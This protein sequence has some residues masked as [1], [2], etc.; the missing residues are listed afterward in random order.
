M[1]PLSERQTAEIDLRIRESSGVR[2]GVDVTP[3]GMLSIAV[4][5][6]GILLSTAVLVRTSVRE[7]K[8]RPERS[9]D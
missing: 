8:R 7:G 3:V 5:V 6:S 9:L 1:S 4:L 2:M